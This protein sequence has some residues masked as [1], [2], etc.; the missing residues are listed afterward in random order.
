ML[1]SKARGVWV[2]VVLDPGATA[3]SSNKTTVERTSWGTI[4]L[5]N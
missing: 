1:V 2:Q 4:L 5:M 3:L